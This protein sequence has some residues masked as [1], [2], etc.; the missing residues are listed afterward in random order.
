MSAT[1][2]EA[3]GTYQGRY[4][5]PQ[6]FGRCWQQQPKGL[7]RIVS[8]KCVKQHEGNKGK[9]HQA[10]CR[11]RSSAH[12]GAGLLCKA[13]PGNGART[14]RPWASR[15]MVESEERPTEVRV[16][17]ARI[18]SLAPH[19]PSLTTTPLRTPG[20]ASL[21]CAVTPRRCHSAGPARPPRRCSARPLCH[22]CPLS[23]AA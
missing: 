2:C 21:H 18:I 16:Q 23:R 6:W 5:G 20:P 9:S 12:A 7:Q 1:R 14:D 22:G 4:S 17:A 11:R 3:R 15:R 13:E 10:H 8:G 19:T